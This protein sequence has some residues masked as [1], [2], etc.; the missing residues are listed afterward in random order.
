MACR[1]WSAPA[2]IWTKVRKAGGKVGLFCGQR[3][4]KLALAP[5]ARCPCFVWGTWENK[6][7]SAN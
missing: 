2:I 6:P 5:A 7:C 1:S 3:G 4:R